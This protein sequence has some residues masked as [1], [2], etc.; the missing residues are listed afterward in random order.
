M[1]VA[2]VVGVLLVLGMAIVTRLPVCDN[3]GHPSDLRG[4]KRRLQPTTTSV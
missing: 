4:R 3:R 1:M 2:S